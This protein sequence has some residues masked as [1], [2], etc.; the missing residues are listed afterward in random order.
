MD[1][2][3]NKNTATVGDAQ[4]A[5]YSQYWATC[6]P[7]YLNVTST[8]ATFGTELYGLPTQPDDPPA[9]TALPVQDSPA[10]VQARHPKAPGDPSLSFAVDV[11]NFEVTTDSQGNDLFQVPGD[12]SFM[13]NA[14]APY[15]PLVEK[16]FL[17]PA[18]STVN[19]VTLDEAAWSAPSTRARSTCRQRFP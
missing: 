19:S 6:K 2:L 5:A 4:V 7:Q 17:L 13:I 12:S 18:G 3:L 16:S 9:V 14:F 11:P 1:N 10:A 15:L 8:Y